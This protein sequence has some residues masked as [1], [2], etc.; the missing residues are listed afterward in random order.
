MFS[1]HAP[2]VLVSFAVLGIIA[3]AVACGDDDTTL[4]AAP[5]DA[6][7]GIAVCGNGILEAAEEC[8]GY[9]TRGA[10]C[11]SMPRPSG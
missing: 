9:E 5:L 2:R 1:Q 8:E 7:T 11:D 6:G 4:A 3:S 10:T